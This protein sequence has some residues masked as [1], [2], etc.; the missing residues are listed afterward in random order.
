MEEEST[1]SPSTRNVSALGPYQK[2]ISQSHPPDRQRNH[3]GLG[4]TTLHALPCVL[5][6]TLVAASRDPHALPLAVSHAAAVTGRLI[7]TKRFTGSDRFNLISNAK[8]QFYPSTSISFGRHCG[9]WRSRMG[10]IKRKKYSRRRA[11]TAR[12]EHPID[13]A[14]ARP[15]DKPVLDVA[16]ARSYKRRPRLAMLGAVVLSRSTRGQSRLQ[17]SIVVK[18][19]DMAPR[20]LITKTGLDGSR[21][22]PRQQARPGAREYSQR[23]RYSAATPPATSSSSEAGLSVSALG[24][25][26]KHISQSH[27][28]DRQRNHSGLGTTTLH[29]LPCVLYFTLVA[30]SRDPHALPLAVSHAA[31]VTGRLIRTKRFTGSDRFNLISNAKRQFYP[32][33]SISFGRSITAE[34]A[35]DNSARPVQGQYSRR[36]ALTA[37]TEHPIDQAQAR[38]EDKPVLDVAEARSYKRRPRLAMLGAVVLSRSTRGQSRLQL[39]IVVKGKDMAPRLLITKTGLD[40]SREGPRQQARPGA[41][42]YSQRFS[43]NATSYQQLI[44]S[45]VTFLRENELLIGATRL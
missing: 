28:P 35:G 39:S 15:E 9:L 25:Y 37:R 27:P 16:E 40:G 45:W 14:Q 33:T 4:T 7:R 32:S 6:F 44:R 13:Q 18:G 8:R 26:Q 21:E 17:L 30:A 20:L 10:K 23:F 43:G 19:K 11:L 31:A 29:A 24:P 5:Y 1:S 2:H 36:R 12:T 34:G 22:G 42:E 3:S 38:P 41:R